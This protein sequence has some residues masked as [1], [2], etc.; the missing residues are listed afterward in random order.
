MPCTNPRSVRY[1]QDPWTLSTEH[2][3]SMGATGQSKYN[4]YCLS[5]AGLTAI[6]LKTQV[7][8]TNQVSS[9]RV[10]HA[11]QHIVYSVTLPTKCNGAHKRSKYR[12]LMCCMLDAANHLLPA[13]SDSLKD[14]SIDTAVDR[15]HSQP[16]ELHKRWGHT[17]KTTF[18]MWVT[19]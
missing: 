1:V 15:P 5:L 18:L 9:V 7:R 14:R 16:Q 17:M 13:A 8:C 12:A 19:L 6:A 2:R 10:L 3:L 11:S 4:L